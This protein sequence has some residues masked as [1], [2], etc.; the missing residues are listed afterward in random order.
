MGEARA[1]GGAAAAAAAAGAPAASTPSAPPPIFYVDC[2][3]GSDSGAGSAAAPW[4][5]LSRAQAAVRAAGPA[6]S[7][8]FLRGDC[9]PRDASGAFDGAAAILTLDAS[10]SGGAGAPSTWAAWPGSAPRLLGGV[11]IPASAWAP[12]GAAAP[13]PGTLMADLGAGGV[14]VARWGLGALASGGLGQ[15]VDTMAELFFNGAPQYQARYPNIEP[16]GAWDWLEIE[17]VADGEHAYLVNGTAAAHALTWPAATSP[18][19]SAWVH[20]CKTKKTRALNGAPQA[21]A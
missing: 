12:A 2:T 3:H 15:C 16:D 20:G 4:A 13:A 21:R 5:T 19:A 1:G 10:D 14:D 11:A 18:G 7:T 8:V 9:Y 6:G 17:K